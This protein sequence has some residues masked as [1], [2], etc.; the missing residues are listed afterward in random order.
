M[1]ESEDQQTLVP[2]D[3]KHIL[4]KVPELHKLGA[5]LDSVSFDQPIDSS[6]MMPAHWAHL[7]HQVEVNYDQYDGFVILHGSD[8]LAYTASALSFM[9]EG[10]RKTNNSDRDLNCQSEEFERMPGKI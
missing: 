8:T 2:F 7:A 1:V 9:F 3:L 10:L 6:D 5:E 4:E